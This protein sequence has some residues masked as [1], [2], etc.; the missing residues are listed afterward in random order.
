MVA[1]F[2]DAGLFSGEVLVAKDG[3]VVFRQ[4][5][6]MAD[7]EWDV[8][9][10]ADTEFRLGSITK[11]FTATAILQLAEQGRLGLDDP[12]S[13]YYTAA[14]AAW[15]GVTLRHLLT[16][17]SGI[18]SYTDIPGFFGNPARADRTPAEIVALTQDKPLTFPPGTG[19][20]YDNS[21]YI[22]LGYVIEKVSGQTYEAYLRDHI[23]GPLGMAHTGYDVSTRIL[24]HRA[25]GYTLAAGGAATNA[26]YLSMTLPYSAG[27]LYS[28]VDDLL[29]W[30]QALYDAKPLTAASLKAMFTDYGHKYGFGYVIDS[31]NG[32][33]LWMH[34]GGINGFSTALLRFPDDHLTVVVLAN[35]DSAPA[36]RIANVLADRWFG[37]APPVAVAVKSEVL[38][39]YVGDYQV[40]PRMIMHIRRSGD[41]LTAQATNQ[42]QTPLVATDE[43]T[44]VSPLVD[45]P[46]SFD[47]S[48]DGKAP[49]LVIHQG[50]HDTPGK[51][52]DAATAAKVEAG[53]P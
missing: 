38:D 3:K 25:S 10:G 33:R 48:V 13:K 26:A 35:I 41:H 53:N 8:P 24:P 22:L 36:G 21:G 30:D 50:G 11:Q 19:Y 44:F 23:F 1:P 32:H 37:V 5:F 39:R 20:A 12:I 42:G 52:V 51:R 45:A 18:P 16:H 29:T 15:S 27:S 34:N 40:T 28:T 14:P 6:G 2:V 43:R 49:G 17:S 4:G 7:R 31:R 47:A 9:V 46:I